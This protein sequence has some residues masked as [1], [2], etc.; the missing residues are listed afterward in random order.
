MAI[1]TVLPGDIRFEQLSHGQNARFPATARERASRIALCDSSEDVA[2]A[3]ERF[4]HAGLRPTVRAGGHCYEDFVDNNPQG[5]IIDISLLTGTTPLSNRSKYRLGA[6]TTLGTAYQELYKRG[7]VTIP[8]GTCAQVGAGG[9]MRV[10]VVSTNRTIPIFC[11]LAA[12]LE[13]VILASSQIFILM[14][15][16]RRPPRFCMEM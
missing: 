15:F 12:E 1:E 9:H 5:A 7:L 6:G 16:P 14:R 2:E 11:G 10:S 4:V 3:V 8:G 13:E